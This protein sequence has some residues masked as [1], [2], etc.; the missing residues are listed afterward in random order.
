MLV[1]FRQ[2]PKS[3]RRSALLVSA[4]FWFYLHFLPW[5]YRNILKA[6]NEEVRWKIRN[7]DDCRWVEQL[8]LIGIQESSNDV[9]Q[10]YPHYQVPKAKASLLK[11]NNNNLI[12]KSLP[13]TYFSKTCWNRTWLMV[14]NNVIRFMIALDLWQINRLP[15]DLWKTSFALVKAYVTHIFCRKKKE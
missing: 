10:E 14:K 15:S 2:P 1:A 3:D 6:K 11:H 12:S 7:P 8:R 9:L 5:L 13:H 4:L